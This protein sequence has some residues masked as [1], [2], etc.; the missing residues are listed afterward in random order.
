[1]QALNYKTG[2]QE[3]GPSDTKIKLPYRSKKPLKDA[4]LQRSAEKMFVSD[5][6]ECDPLADYSESW[7]GVD[8]PEEDE[9]NSDWLEVDILHDTGTISSENED[10]SSSDPPV[11][12]DTPDL[13]SIPFSANAGLQVQKS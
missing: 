6:E 11:W 8:S 9:G 12:I 3:A 1:M 4:D 5:D 7:S 13:N 10:T 2:D